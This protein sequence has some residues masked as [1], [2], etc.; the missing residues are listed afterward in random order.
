MVV[1]RGSVQGGH[2]SETSLV[3]LCSVS[4]LKLQNQLGAISGCQR[5]ALSAGRSAVTGCGMAALQFSVEPG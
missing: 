2:S 1:L 3:G 5:E 4:K